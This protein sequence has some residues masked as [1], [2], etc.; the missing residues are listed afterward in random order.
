MHPVQVPHPRPSRYEAPVDVAGALDLLAL[1]G[2]RARPIAGGTD[3][4]LEIERGGRAPFDVLVDTTRIADF[5][6]ITAVGDRIV[7]GG[8]VT[9]NDVIASPLAVDRL[10]PL[11][12]ACLEIGAPAL[13]NRAT[14]AGNVVT[15]SP[16]NDTISALLALD[17]TVTLTSNAGARELA[18]DDFI[19]GFRTTDRR[20]DELVTAISPAG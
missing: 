7:L 2:E 16:A 5:N 17:A 3:L 19:T 20:P 15:A 12:Q 18:L 6:S 1:H 11:A 8:G 10:L 13:R 4:F 14:V 9:H